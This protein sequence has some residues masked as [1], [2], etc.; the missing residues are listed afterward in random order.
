MDSQVSTYYE[1]GRFLGHDVVGCIYDV[2][3][4]PRQRPGDVPVLDENG[5]KIVRDRDGTGSARRTARNGA[6]P[7]T[8]NSAT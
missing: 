7:R 2:V 3:F 6:R 1:G 8:P 5:L 4:K